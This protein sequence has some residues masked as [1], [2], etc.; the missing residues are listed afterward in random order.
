MGTLGIVL[1]G[2]DARAACDFLPHGNVLLEAGAEC[3]RGDLAHHLAVRAQHVGVLASGG[4]RAHEAHAA[5]ADALRQLLLDDVTTQE[6]KL[7]TAA[8]AWAKRDID[9]K[10]SRLRKTR[11]ICVLAAPHMM[12]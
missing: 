5:L 4:T 3:T 7:L 1:Y 10:L 11:V 9:H 8:L 12:L 2:N 6:V